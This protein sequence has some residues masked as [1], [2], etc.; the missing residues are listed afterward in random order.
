VLL[1]RDNIYEFMVLLV[2]DNIYEFMVLLV[3][4]AFLGGLI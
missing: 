3:T 1:V 4:S 2:R